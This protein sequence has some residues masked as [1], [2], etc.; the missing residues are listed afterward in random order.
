MGAQKHRNIVIRGVIYPDAK[1]AAEAFGLNSDTVRL[2]VRTGRADR[3]GTGQ[4]GH[5][6]APVTIR[7]VTYASAKAAAAALGCPVGTIMAARCKGT[8]DKVAKQ[9]LRRITRDD[10]EPLWSRAD[11]TIDRMAEVLGVTRQAVSC[12]AKALGLPSRAWN[13]YSPAPEHAFRRMWLAGVRSREIAAH[14]GYSQVKSV[15]QRA[16]KLGLPKRGPGTDIPFTSLSAYLE[17][18]LAGRMAA[19]A[20]RE[21]EDRK[22]RKA[23]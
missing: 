17:P 8:L 18:A 6:P 2:M 14:F 3:I 22:R 7:G 12:K 23:A 5:T 16:R 1:T 10:L 21:A 19:Q 20:A 15:T 9:P 11:I 13:R 4:P